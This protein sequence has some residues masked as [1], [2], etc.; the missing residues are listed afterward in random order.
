MNRTMPSRRIPNSRLMI[1]SNRKKRMRIVMIRTNPRNYDNNSYAGAALRKHFLGG[2]KSQALALAGKSQRDKTFPELLEWLE[3]EYEEEE[4][5]KDIHRR[6]QPNKDGNSPKY[7]N[8]TNTY[9][10]QR[11]Q[12]KNNGFDQNNY[13]RGNNNSNS[14]GP[15]KK[16][17]YNQSRRED[18]I[19]YQP[20]RYDSGRNNDFNNSRTNGNSTNGNNQWRHNR[21]DSYERNNAN[22]P[23]YN[24]TQ[25]QHARQDNY[26]R[27]SINHSREN[28]T[29]WRQDR[30][31]GNE[32][33]EGYH[34]RER[35]SQRNLHQQDSSKN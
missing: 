28:R 33:V 17:Q 3:R 19:N 34:P 12:R 26:E 16:Y 24:G 7:N 8:N 29:Q 30:R 9:G 11:F 10:N 27:G 15:N 25:R 32:I 22:Y 4:E 14:T 18:E 13:Q 1:S 35:E 31:E 23:R 20:H 6:L 21:Q 5:L 2:L